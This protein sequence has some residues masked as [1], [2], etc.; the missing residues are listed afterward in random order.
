MSPARTGSVKNGCH[1]KMIAENERRGGVEEEGK[2]EEA[3]KVK[4]EETLARL[5]AG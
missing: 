5:G 2:R 1:L 4:L 3:G